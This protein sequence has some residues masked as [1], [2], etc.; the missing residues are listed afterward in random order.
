M[1]KVN[2]F[3]KYSISVYSSK[4]SRWKS[5]CISRDRT[6]L[7]PVATQF[8]HKTHSQLL[9]LLLTYLNYQQHIKGMRRVCTYR[10][11][12]NYW[13]EL[14]NSKEGSFERY[15]RILQGPLLTNKQTGFVFVLLQG[16]R[17]ATQTNYWQEPLNS[18]KVIFL[19]FLLQLFYYSF[20]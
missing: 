9:F 17:M 7:Q 20:I 14:V 8:L 1:L 13:Q 3:I 5:N 18:K 2:I 6:Q 10:I 16:A 19:H 15:E 4:P 11:L 12:P